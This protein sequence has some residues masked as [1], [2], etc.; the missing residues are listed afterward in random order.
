MTCRSIRLVREP[1]FRDRARSKRRGLPSIGLSLRSL[2]HVG[3]R[4]AADD[5]DGFLHQQHGDH[6]CSRAGDGGNFDAQRH[7][8]GRK[9][10]AA[11]KR[12]VALGN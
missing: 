8:R 4:H 9:G 10:A 2:T 12:K 5:G 1:I 6:R 11:E 7:R 3:H